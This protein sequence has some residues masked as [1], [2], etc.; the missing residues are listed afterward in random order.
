MT[1]PPVMP[2]P[3][4]VIGGYLGAGKTT[5]VNHLLRNAEGRRICVLVNDFGEIAIDADLIEAREGDSL[6]LANGCVCCSIGGDLF[7]ALS[8]VLDRTPRP[9]HLVIEAS[10]VAEPARIAAVAHAEPDL[11]A[12]AVV[13]LCDAETLADRLAEPLLAR[14]VSEQIAAADLLLL[15]KCD[16]VAE[17]TLDALQDLLRQLNETAEIKRVE[18]S[19]APVESLLAEPAPRMPRDVAETSSHEALYERWSWESELAHPIE[20]VEQALAALPGG[21]LRLKGLLVSDDRASAWEIQ[22]TGSRPTVVGR[23]VPPGAPSGLRLV[24]IALRGKLDRAALDRRLVALQ[25]QERVQG[26]VAR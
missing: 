19:A 5:L 8:R 23:P 11:S 18:F 24:A 15:N 13:V 2:L 26:E 12:G 4:T 6:T 9:D 7:R 25:E 10:G 21:L 16:S 20:R 22:S 3:M 14:T 17:E 1:V